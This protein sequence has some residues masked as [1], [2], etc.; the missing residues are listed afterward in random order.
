MSFKSCEY[1]VP[2]AEK[3]Q[4]KELT[5][6]G[7]LLDSL[8]VNRDAVLCGS[9]YTTLSTP[10]LAIISIYTSHEGTSKYVANK[11]SNSAETFSYCVPVKQGMVV[12]FYL[13]SDS[14]I[15]KGTHSWFFVN[16]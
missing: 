10:A 7:T 8:T 14:L 15:S 11:E 3:V 5:Q 2:S 4:S 9:I 1:L 12:N 13:V 16:Q 6:N